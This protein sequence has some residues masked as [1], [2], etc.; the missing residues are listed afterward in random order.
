MIRRHFIISVDDAGSAWSVTVMVQPRNSNHVTGGRY[1]IEPH[2]V[3]WMIRRVGALIATHGNDMPRAF[4]KKVQQS[5]EDLG[6]TWA[7]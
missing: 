4:L 5:T 3:E 7:P 2:N 1:D 6:G